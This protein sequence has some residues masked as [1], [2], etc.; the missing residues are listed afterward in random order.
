MT[1]RLFLL[2]LLLVTSVGNAANQLTITGTEGAYLELRLALDNLQHTR[3]SSQEKSGDAQRLVARIQTQQCFADTLNRLLGSVLVVDIRTPKALS[4]ANVQGQIDGWQI[5]IGF[6]PS[7]ED[8]LVQILLPFEQGFDSQWGRIASESSACC[9]E[10]R[11]ANGFFMLHHSNDTYLLTPIEP[12]PERAQ[13]YWRNF[14]A[15]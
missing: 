10:I 6:D 1:K 12:T 15:R 2:S 8:Q 5:E 7:C 14:Y 3:L 9:G 13:R 11:Q 4:G